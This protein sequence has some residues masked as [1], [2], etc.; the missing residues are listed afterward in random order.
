MAYKTELS[1]FSSVSHIQFLLVTH[2][3]SPNP[4]GVARN[5]KADDYS[6]L[7]NQKLI[8]PPLLLFLLQLLSCVPSGIKSEVSSLSL[9]PKERRGSCN[10]LRN[11]SE[12]NVLPFLGVEN[13]QMQYY[14]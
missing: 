5:G 10:N 12:V 2:V 3:S 9:D 13:R 7:K 6:V 4:G 8:N 1:V 11:V 14:M